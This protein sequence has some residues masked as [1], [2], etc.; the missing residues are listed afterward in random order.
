MIFCL[1]PAVAGTVLEHLNKEG[2]V[3]KRE[4]AFVEK[5]KDHLKAGADLMK[6]VRLFL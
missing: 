4:V 1:F 5:V 3:G 2:L 6:Q